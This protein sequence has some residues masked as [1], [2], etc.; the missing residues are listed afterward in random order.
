VSDDQPFRLRRRQTP[1]AFQE[2][3]DYIHDQHGLPP[4]MT[5]FH[6][7]RLRESALEAIALGTPD[8]AQI[9]RAALG[10]EPNPHP[11]GIREEPRP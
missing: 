11:L 2:A 7:A 8:P 3:L 9:A 6:V 4:R 10:Y 5:D 1:E